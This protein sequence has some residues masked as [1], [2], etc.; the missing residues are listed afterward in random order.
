MEFSYKTSFI[1]TPLF[2][3]V[4]HSLSHTLMVKGFPVLPPAVVIVTL[5]P[6]SVLL[7]SFFFV[8]LFLTFSPGVSGV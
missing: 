8:L 6:L 4:S 7:L 1:W 3:A 2:L 5:L